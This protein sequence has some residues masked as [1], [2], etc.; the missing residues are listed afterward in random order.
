MTALRDE[1]LALRRKRAELARGKA[2]LQEELAQGEE[3][4]LGL[5]QRLEEAA[6]QRRA[7]RA[8]G[9]QCEAR[10]RELEATLQDYAA[11]VDAL[12]RRARDRATGRRC[13]PSR[14]FP[15]SLIR[16]EEGFQE[17]CRFFLPPPPRPCNDA[18]HTRCDPFSLH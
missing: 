18:V 16:F 7:L 12:R 17:S 14:R 10:Q 6:E 15:A 3:Q 5:R 11:K 2:A 9:E 4:V 13:P 8:R 1:V